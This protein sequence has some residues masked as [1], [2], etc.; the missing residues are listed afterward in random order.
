MKKLITLFALILVS[1]NLL[2]INYYW[3]G[4]SGNWSDYNNHWATT[5][6]GIG[7][8]FH[9]QWPQSTDNVF[10]DA[11]SFT[12]PGQIVT[13]DQGITS[14][15]DM[16]W[17]TLP[18]V[19]PILYGDSLKTLRIWGSLTISTVIGFNFNGEVVME[20]NTIGKTISTGGTP[21]NFHWTFNGTGGGWTFQSAL[22][23]SSV[24]NLINGNLN[25]NTLNP[26]GLLKRNRKSQ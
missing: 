18:T 8:T 17:T 16:T 12:A 21:I 5:S 7:G 22:M 19:F 25:T 9:N 3:V 15:A 10:F 1:I 13:I 20:A 6:G 4:G 14:C 24:I 11:N 26:Q 2:A 23:G